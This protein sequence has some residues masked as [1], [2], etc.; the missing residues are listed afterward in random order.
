MGDLQQYADEWEASSK[1]HYDNGDY[2]W[3]ESNI[4]SYQRVLEIGCGAGY[5]TQTLLSSG[6]DIVAVDSNPFC[7][8]KANKLLTGFQNLTIIEG[9]I[10]VPS[11]CEELKK[12][13]FDI[14]ICWNVGG[15]YTHEKALEYYK[16]MAPYY[17]EL[18]DDGMNY[19][20][21]TKHITSYTDG[22]YKRLVVER[23]CKLA[24][25][26]HVPF[27]F[28][29]RSNSGI[30]EPTKEMLML[31]SKFGYNPAQIENRCAKALSATG[32]T[33]SCEGEIYSQEVLDIV[34]SSI[35]FQ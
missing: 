14:V 34:F 9:D 27:N 29:E 5:S 26:M 13:S 35:I 1:Y 28:V 21:L 24:A 6:H 31:Q 30:Q 12:K 16:E 17:Q 19:E 2:K 18:L 8:N 20:Y 22:F 33:L 10:T 23:S 7:I 4:H 11:F 15:E 3:M 32:K 25:S